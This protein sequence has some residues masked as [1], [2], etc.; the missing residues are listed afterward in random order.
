[1]GKVGT[2]AAGVDA[3]GGGGATGAAV[4]P[5]EEGDVTSVG[6]DTGRLTGLVC[7]VEPDVVGTLTGLVAGE[8]PDCDGLLAG[9]LA[10]G[11]TKVGRKLPSF[12]SKQ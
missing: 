3:T 2:F 11:G 8:L 1:V 12:G 7:G 10:T 5:L 6:V 9:L 4:V